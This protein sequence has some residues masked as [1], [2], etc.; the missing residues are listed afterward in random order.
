MARTT[1]MR[2]IELMALKQD[3]STVIE[4]LGRKGNFQFQTKLQSG[5]S[6]NSKAPQNIDREFFDNL[7]QTRIFLNVGDRTDNASDCRIPSD[8]DRT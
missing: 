8:E 7:Q 1:E 6:K 4:Y 5:D 3:I 2:L